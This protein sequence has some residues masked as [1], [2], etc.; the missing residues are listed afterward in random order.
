MEMVYEATTR[1]LPRDDD[2]A[3]RRAFVKRAKE[4]QIRWGSIGSVVFGKHASIRD[5]MIETDV[6]TLRKCIDNVE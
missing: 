6:T 4:R 3:F 2:A 5:W 1:D